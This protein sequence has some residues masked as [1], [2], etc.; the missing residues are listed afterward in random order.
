MEAHKLSVLGSVGVGKSACVVQLVA[1][2]FVE[3]Y[4]PS[5]EDS[6]R[7]N[8]EVDGKQILLE[9]LD[10]ASMVE[11]HN[12]MR[13]MYFRE[14]C[15][16][17]IIYSITSRQSFDEVASFYNDCIRRIKNVERFPTV[18]IGNKCDLEKERQVSKEEGQ[19]LASLFGCPFFET[20]AKTKINITT[21]FHEV[22][23]E[24]SRHENVNIPVGSKS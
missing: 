8:E 21:A 12:V 7:K 19:E 18:I 9:I 2:V 4:D 20:S 3:K 24:L 13:D 14:T 22:V 11:P 5:I 16:F 15:G 17:L 6:Y 23:R 1:G 10:T